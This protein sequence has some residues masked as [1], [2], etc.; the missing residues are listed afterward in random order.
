MLFFSYLSTKEERERKKYL[1]LE[2]VDF[3]TARGVRADGVGKVLL[4]WEKGER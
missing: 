3:E 4:F 2:K 1:Y